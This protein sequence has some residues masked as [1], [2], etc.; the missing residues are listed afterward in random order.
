MLRK[1]L[2]R[3]GRMCGPARYI[4]ER[5]MQLAL[6]LLACALLLTTAD[7]DDAAYTKDRRT[8]NAMFETAE[9]VLLMGALLPVIVEDQQSRR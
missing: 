6:T 5:C 9:S 2:K 3:M 7:P 4:F 8:A 1:A